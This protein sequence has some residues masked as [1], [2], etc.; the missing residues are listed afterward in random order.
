MSV[1]KYKPVPHNHAEFLA[2]TRQHP[3]FNDA[4]KSLA[5]EYTVAS[6]LLK[7]PSK[8]GLTQDEV[9]ERM[10]TAKSAVSRLEGAGLHPPSLATLKKYAASGGRDLRAKLV[11]YKAALCR[12]GHSIGW[13]RHG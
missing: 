12:T 13:L 5:L 9:T 10:G 7:A 8:A 4:Y 2:T 1:L 3:G 11:S 6:Q